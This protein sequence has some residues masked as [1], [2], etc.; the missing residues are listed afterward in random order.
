MSVFLALRCVAG[1]SVSKLLSK[2]VASEHKPNLQTI[3]DPTVPG[4]IA[5]LFPRDRRV[6]EIPG[7]GRKTSEILKTCFGGG[8]S[9][10]ISSNRAA[11]VLTR[12]GLPL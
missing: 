5:Q 6:R 4:A 11:T 10:F 3:V 7:I 8:Q 9:R 2:L 1:V 12:G